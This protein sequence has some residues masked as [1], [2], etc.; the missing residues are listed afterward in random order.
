MKQDSGVTLTSLIIYVIAM[1]MVVAIVGTLTTLYYRNVDNLMDNTEQA[2]EYTTFNSYFTNE[3][4]KKENKVLEDISSSNKIIFSSGNQYTFV[5]EAIYMNQVLICKYVK[6]CEFNYNN[7]T[8]QITVNI[9]IGDKNY[10]NTYNLNTT[11]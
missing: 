3:I 10:N 5:G 8:K 4:N 11:K 6:S 1:V 7:T 2:K 9:T